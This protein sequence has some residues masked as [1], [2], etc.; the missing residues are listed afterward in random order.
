M[1][2][3]IL[4][5]VD[6]SEPSIAAVEYAF[7]VFPDAELT[8]I[9]VVDELEAHYGGERADGDPEFFEPIADLAADHGTEIGTRVA[10]G[11][12]AETIVAAAEEMDEIVI[13]SAGRSGVSRMLLGSVAEAVARG[14]P[15]PVTIVGP[16]R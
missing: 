6:G 7:E 3:R 16:S 12:P 8:A 14:S 15:V 1:T 11:T 9:H 5:A 4:L 13:G 2:R 10:S